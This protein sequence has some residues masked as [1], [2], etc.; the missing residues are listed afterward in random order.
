MP[1]EDIKYDFSS[2]ELGFLIAKIDNLYFK[3]RNPKS[4]TIYEGI[5]KKL[6]SGWPT[7]E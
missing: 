5:L 7:E 6:Y 2:H 4:K 1:T 3:E